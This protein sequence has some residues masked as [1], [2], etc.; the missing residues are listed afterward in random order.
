MGSVGPRVPADVGGA[1]RAPGPTEQND[2]VLTGTNGGPAEEAGGYSLTEAS[3]CGKYEERGRESWG[4][5]EAPNRIRT[6]LRRLYGTRPFN[7]LKVTREGFYHF[8]GFGQAL[9]CALDSFHG[10][11]RTPPMEHIS[12][13]EWEG[14]SPV[15]ELLGLLCGGCQPHEV[16][17]S[18]GDTFQE[19][20]AAP[21]PD[22]N[23]LLVPGCQGS[24]GMTG[25]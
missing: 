20:P 1:R 9:G 13:E 4:E 24:E 15:C 3:A 25:R 19:S 18:P 16:P 17:S 14:K 10:D 12:R 6:E 22:R 7:D 8:G 5:R 23:H 11:R 2:R 21:T